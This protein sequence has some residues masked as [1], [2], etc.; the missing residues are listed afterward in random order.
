MALTYA[1]LVYAPGALAPAD[2]GGY[3]FHPDDWLDEL[4]AWG[5]HGPDD[6][7]A[8]SVRQAMAVAHTMLAHGPGLLEACTREPCRSVPVE[9]LVPDF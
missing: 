9:S 7:P 4:E 3:E 8:R 6:C 2:D 1:G 5:W